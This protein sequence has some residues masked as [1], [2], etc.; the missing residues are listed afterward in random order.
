MTHTLKSTSQQS[1]RLARKLATLKSRHAMAPFVHQ[2][3]V[4]M[5]LGIA[6]AYYSG[7]R[8]SK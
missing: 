5:K 2:W 1:R 3:A 8:F 7:P 6:V 4:A